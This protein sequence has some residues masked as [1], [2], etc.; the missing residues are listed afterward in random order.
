M[1]DF[2]RNLIGTNQERVLTLHPSFWQ[3]HDQLSLDKKKKLALEAPITLEEIR[4]VIFS[5][6]PSEASDP[7]CF[8]F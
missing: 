5:C 4:K 2:Y 3:T 1:T 7:D 8:S 6:N